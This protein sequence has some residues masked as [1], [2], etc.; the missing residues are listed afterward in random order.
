[1]V[2]AVLVLL[3][4][5]AMFGTPTAV[6]PHKPA[7][8]SSTE[9]SYIQEMTKFVH[10]ATDSIVYLNHQITAMEG[11]IRDLQSQLQSMDVPAVAVQQP[12]SHPCNVPSSGDI[13]NSIC[14]TGPETRYTCPPDRILLTD[15]GNNK[16]CI[17][18]TTGF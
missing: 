12:A 2:L 17:L 18:F 6:A 3:L 15:E 16:H 7:S 1:M 13:T 5:A 4:S 14:I 10:T 8:V 11:E 9:D